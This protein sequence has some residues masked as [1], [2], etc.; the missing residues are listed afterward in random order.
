MPVSQAAVSNEERP[1][2]RRRSRRVDAR[3]RI[4]FTRDGTSVVIESETDDISVDG[5]FVRTHRRPPDVG[6][7]LGLILKFEETEQEIMVSGVV[8]RVQD[9]DGAERS[10]GMGIRFVDLDGDRRD[11]LRK[12]IEGTGAY[13]AMREKTGEA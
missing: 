10:P 11:A 5:A 12:A 6:T 13:R 2:E 4:L 7:K 8:A 3:L 1:Q 9:G